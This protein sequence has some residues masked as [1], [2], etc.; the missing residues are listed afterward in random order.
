MIGASG[1]AYLIPKKYAFLAFSR[2]SL[3]ESWRFNRLKSS[4]LQRMAKLQSL[5]L[6]P[7]RLPFRHGGN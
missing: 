1:R 6:S 7:W 2:R 4:M 3:I 5:I